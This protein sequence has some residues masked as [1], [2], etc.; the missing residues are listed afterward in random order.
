LAGIAASGLVTELWHRRPDFAQRLDGS[1][2]SRALILCQSHSL[3][4][5]LSILHLGRNRHNLIVK[6]P[7][8]LRVLC[9]VERLVCIHILLK[10]ADVEVVAH[11][12]ARLNHWLHAIIGRRSLEYLIVEGLLEAVA[13]LRHRLGANCK[14]DVDAA[15]RYLVGD[16]LDGFKAGG[17]E[18]VHGRSAGCVREAGCEHGGTDDVG[19]FAVADLFRSVRKKCCLRSGVSVSYVA[20]ADILNESGIHVHSFPDLFQKRVYHKVERGVFHATFLA[21]R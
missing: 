3:P 11:V 4:L 18:S 5:S 13:A 21:F 19:S 10:P 16:V 17:A 8:L 7:R 6:P 1:P 14:T 2:V 20:H 12:L 15:H 9:T